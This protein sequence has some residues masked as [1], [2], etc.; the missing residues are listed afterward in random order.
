M[1]H[2]RSVVVCAMFMFGAFGCSTGEMAATSPPPADSPG[3]ASTL[4]TF[5]RSTAVHAAE[6]LVDAST[7]ERI[8][9]QLRASGSIA[10]ADL[11]ELA[12]SAG[13][14]LGGDAVPEAW[15]LEPQGG[16]DSANLLIAYAPAGNERN[17]TEIPA[18]SL[19]GTR[20]TL[21]AR[22]PPA[23]PVLVI[24][25]NGRLAMQKGVA[26]ANLKLQRAGLQHVAPKITSTAGTGRWTTKLD[27][28]RLVNDEEPWILGAAEIY[29][30]VSS[31]VSDSNTPDL[32]IVDMPY[33]DND[34]T[35]Y[36]PNQIVI[37]WTNYAFQAANIQLFEKD[38][39]TSYQ[40]L[41]TALVTAVG[42]VGSLAGV[43][44]IEAITEIANRVIAAM[45][46]SWFANDDDY[47]DSF[48]TVEKTKTYTGLVGAGNNATVSLSPFFLESN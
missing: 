35:T 37:D 36:T 21:D 1:V 20:V 4:Q 26:E 16:G 18:Y 28:I 46:S 38:D 15:L 47:V 22:Q 12:A 40:D 43:P 48:Y 45:P 9:G 27:S 3:E 13:T 41:V 31:V 25:T 34:G 6:A 30:V 2:W 10:L 33:L 11:P 42:A 19:G 5:K 17:W 14:D 24:E 8:I 39:N 44:A 32:R 29:A 7:R 23:V